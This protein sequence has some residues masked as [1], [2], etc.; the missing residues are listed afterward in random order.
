MSKLLCS[1]CEVL[2]AGLAVIIWM[3]TVSTA[4]SFNFT[5]MVA[6]T[7]LPGISQVYWIG[8]TKVSTGTVPQPLTML[9]VTWLGLFIV[10]VY[11]R[12]AARAR[13]MNERDRPLA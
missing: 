10:W 13:G 9:C 3:A 7:L 2:L 4:S 8:F 12:D 6:T 5:A 11:A 1:T